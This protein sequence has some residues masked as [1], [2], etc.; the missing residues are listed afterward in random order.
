MKKTGKGILWGVILVMV[1][2]SL[3][4]A[5]LILKGNHPQPQRREKIT[6]VTPFPET[7]IYP[8]AREID[9]KDLSRILTNLYVS[10]F[11]NDLTYFVSVLNTNFEYGFEAGYKT[12]TGMLTNREYRKEVI[13]IMKEIL[14]F[15]GSFESEN[16]FCV[17]YIFE[18]FPDEDYD[19]V[20]FFAF[21]AKNV[22]VYP[23]PDASAEPLGLFSYSVVKILHDEFS[24][25]T[26]IEGV[27]WSKI[28]LP[29]G[30]VGFV[31]T[32]YLL[33]PFD[34]RLHFEKIGNRWKIIALVSGD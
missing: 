17:P 11:S 26:N 14:R 34:W 1:V 4:L 16:Y 12:F 9:D 29:E 24:F 25:S 23:V 19:P 20:D 2:F 31:K 8:P 28:G 21:N 6:S 5:Y 22:R 32:K 13:A 3:I 33:S 7:N 15:P 10:V 27:E 30:E 18:D